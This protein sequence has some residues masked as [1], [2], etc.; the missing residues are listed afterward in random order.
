LKMA[1]TLTEDIGE[2][3]LWAKY[4]LLAG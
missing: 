2:K 1:I 3:R 4:G